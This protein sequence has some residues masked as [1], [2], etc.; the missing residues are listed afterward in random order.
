MTKRYLIYTLFVLSLAFLLSA[1]SAIDFNP[2]P[3]PSTLPPANPSATPVLIPDLSTATALPP[4]ATLTPTL[5]P[6]PNVDQV[7][8][9]DPNNGWGWD[10]SGGPVLLRTS[11]GG[12][13][14]QPVAL[15]QNLTLSGW[16][17]FFLNANS[18]WLSAADAQAAPILLRTSDGGQHWD[19]LASPSGLENLG[20]QPGYTFF[21]PQDGIAEVDGVGAGNR[22]VQVYETHDGGQSFQLIPM[23]GTDGENGLPEGTLHLCSICSD[24]F[25]YDLSRVIIVSGDMGSMQPVG[26]VRM[27][28]S[29]DKAQTW[30]SQNLPL[31]AE[32][33]DSLVSPYPIQF[34]GAS[35]GFLPV[36]L[37]NYT[38]TGETT[39]D[40]LVV[41]VTH[42][43]G[44][45]WSLA[46]AHL[47]QV[48]LIARLQFF[49]ATQGM[50]QCGTS[51]CFTS[52]GA[53]SWQPVGADLPADA[54]SNLQNLTFVDTTHGW[55]IVSKDQHAQM[56]R[57]TDGGRN[58]TLLNP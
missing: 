58:W 50:V 51:L 57:T 34:V 9:F 33:A 37:L 43:G 48:P 4:T 26:T 38:A 24:I 45:T 14:W 19:S 16:S 40:V 20:G 30:A 2:P 18:A 52:D 12:L 46:P 17:S 7:T 42:D 1:C 3:L 54:Q 8:M 23:K 55:L 10:W 15:P 21:T 39:T 53:Q 31:P 25:Y 47:E 22:Y 5:A 13:T 29:F 28:I 49:S 6:Y 56:Y 44:N 36:R 35:D 41:Y 27:Q 11:D 32:Y